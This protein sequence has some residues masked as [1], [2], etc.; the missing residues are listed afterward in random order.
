MVFVFPPNV[1]SEKKKATANPQPKDSEPQGSEGGM[2]TVT[3]SKTRGEGSITE[4][5]ES[6]TEGM[7][8]TWRLT[9]SPEG[10]PYYWNDITGG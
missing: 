9:E 6:K 2:S 3:G 8:G 5:E 10:Y 1:V 4:A 7:S